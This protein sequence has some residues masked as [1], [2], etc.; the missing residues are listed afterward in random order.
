MQHSIHMVNYSLFGFLKGT[1]GAYAACQVTEK[2]EDCMRR[3]LQNIQEQ[4][5]K[6]LWILR[7]SKR[8]ALSLG[9]VSV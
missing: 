2:G 7:M 3:A 8:L 5:T 1:V 6:K 4:I 9:K